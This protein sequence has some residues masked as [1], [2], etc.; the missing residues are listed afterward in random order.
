VT[1]IFF[2]L[3]APVVVSLGAAVG[4]FI[5]IMLVIQ[6]RGWSEWPLRTMILYLALS[7]LLSVGLS[8]T[9]WFGL[10]SDVPQA[11]ERLAA[12]LLTASAP[13]MVALTLM[14][15]NRP[16][17]QWVALIGLF[18]LAFV[19]AVDFNLFGLQAQI[20][21]T[22][23]AGVTDPMRP[24]RAAGWA[25]FSAGTLLLILVDFFQTR[26]PLHRNRI[27][28]WMLGLFFLLTG[29]LLMW[30]DKSAFL[31]DVN[32]IG[33]VLRFSGASIL[34]W[35]MISYHLPVLRNVTRRL[36]SAVL[37]TLFIGG[38]IFIGMLVVLSAAQQVLTLGVVVTAILTAVLLAVFIHPL[39][40]LLDRLIDRLAYSGRYN[41][42]R[43]LRD[44]GDA[45]NNIVDL[46]TLS[47]V[48]VGIIAEALDVRRGVL[49]LF[50]RRATEPALDTVIDV[51]IMEG[52]GALDLQVAE[53]SESSPIVQ[54][55]TDCVKPLTQYE[56]DILPAYR[57]A[58]RQEHYWLNALEMEVYA[59]IRD[60]QELVGAFAFGHKESGE[61]Y[62]NQDLD[63]LMTVA[64][65]TTVVLQNA[66]LVSDLRSANTSITRLNAELT[67]SNRRLEKLDKAKTDFIEIASHELRTPLTQVRGYSDIL[68]DM[69]QQGGFVAAHMNQISQGVTRASVR[70]EQIISAMLDVSRIDAQALDIRTASISVAAAVKMAVD[71]YK[72]A[73][74][75]RKLNV[76]ISELDGLPHVQG[77][78][79]RLCQAFGNLVGNA[80]KFTPDGGNITISGRTLEDNSNSHP[81][82]FVEVMFA[83]T[84]IG[85]D[86]A[87]Q[88][89]IFEKFYRVG[90]VELHSTG[91]TK[92]KGAGPGLG[93][94]IAKGVIQAHGGKIWVESPG[95]DESRM[96]G[97]IFHIVLPVARP[98]ALS[99]TGPLRSKT[100][101][102]RSKN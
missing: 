30:L 80:I 13:L 18:W 89:L 101:P 69:V 23:P 28:F 91:S 41:P 90:A 17:A 63:V 4:Y 33:A 72:D 99:K 38:L 65:Q 16:G 43:A 64:N 82:A 47:T 27:L 98:A 40:L 56:I 68:A 67:E 62:S 21:G 100:G 39:R 70:L 1:P 35:A 52:M 12:D 66:R 86:V 6:R 5:L 46:N 60:K 51:V 14:F 53:F 31:I 44:Y 25:G 96:P 83:D 15:V 58:P 71:N 32:Q 73:I 2:G 76:Q 61:P 3:Q 92:F 55:L 77:D 94:P 9:V 24:L 84:G 59:P 54:Y 19:V 48:A 49:M 87:D 36:T 93:L 29:E 78:L 45:I 102:L 95:H 57:S 74:R 26:R 42:A 75:D 79:Q 10:R 7:V 8:L 85:I 20:L 81:Q 88:G 50:N 34:T 37:T 97:S 22:V 11:G